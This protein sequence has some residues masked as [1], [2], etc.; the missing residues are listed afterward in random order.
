[1]QIVKP[2]L[3][4]TALAAA[5]GS[6]YVV[7][8]PGADGERHGKRFPIDLAMVEQR[9]SERFAVIDTDDNEQ[10]S[11]EEF[12]AASSD[13][14]HRKGK[15]KRKGGKK[16]RGDQHGD[17]LSDAQRAERKAAFE[18]ELFTAMDTDGDGQLSATE[19][20]SENRRASARALMRERHFAKLDSNADGQ[21]SRVEFGARLERMQ[22]ADAD[23]DGQLSRAEARS[24]RRRPADV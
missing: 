14:K 13:G 6:A 17:P 1:M 7:A 12:A 16:G 23:G 5:V 2:I 20:S 18:S 11:A 3:I 8:A 9:T 24:L 4:A 21:L 10:I 22:A 15:G 19:A